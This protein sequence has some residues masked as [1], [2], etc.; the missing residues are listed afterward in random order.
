MEQDVQMTNDNAVVNSFTSPNSKS[1]KI[2]Q[3][4]EKYRFIFLFI[5]KVA[6]TFIGIAYFLK[7][8]PNSLISDSDLSRHGV[9]SRGAYSVAHP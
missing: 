3:G 1:R 2:D 9:Y 4:N 7:N 6:K 8:A 5:A